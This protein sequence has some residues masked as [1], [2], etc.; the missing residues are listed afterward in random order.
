MEDDVI[1]ILNCVTKIINR[2]GVYIMQKRAED[3]ALGEEF[4]D[5]FGRYTT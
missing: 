2:Q 5:K 3:R 4:P 1:S